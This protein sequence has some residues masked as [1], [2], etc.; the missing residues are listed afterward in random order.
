M[1]TTWTNL[2]T[3][4]AWDLLNEGDMADALEAAEAGDEGHALHLHAEAL[5]E[6]LYPA[7]VVAL[8]ADSLGKADW[9]QLAQVV[10]EASEEDEG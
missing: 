9:E 2:E 10:I 5:A 7:F 4:C 6:R 1:T 3:D 8:M